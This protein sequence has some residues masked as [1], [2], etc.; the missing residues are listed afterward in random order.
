VAIGTRQAGTPGAEKARVYLESELSAAGLKPVRETFRQTT[1]CGELEFSNLFVDLPPAVP[2]KDASW[3]LLCTHYD[4]K[5][6]P[7]EFLGAN[8]GG[9]G[10]A[11]LLELARALSKAP[12]QEYGYRLLFLDGEEA[13]NHEWVDPDNR[14]GSRYHAAKLKESGRAA[15]FKACVLLD[16]IGDK[17]LVID[18]EGYSDARL[19]TAFSNAARELK[20]GERITAKHGLEIID[21]HR[22]FM[23]VGI[24]SVDLIDFS[25][26]P[27]NA[28][29]H[30]LDDKLENCSKASLDI[31]GRVTLRALPALE[32]Q[33]SGY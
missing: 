12:P 21:D 29:W 3:I 31:V 25:Y 15:H 20:L 27:K 30:T 33:L 10:S 26:G 5:R 32:K 22:M 9:S 17:D 14:Y 24:R 11:V 19:Y 16:M 1:P 23:D 8:D 2:G 18:Q 7:G 28:W 13:V 4:T 6:L